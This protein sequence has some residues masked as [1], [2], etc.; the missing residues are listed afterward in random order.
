MDMHTFKELLDRRIRSTVDTLA[1]KSSEYSTD[2][3]LHNFK[4]AA[5]T[6]GSSPGEVCWNYMMKHL[7]SIQDMATGKKVFP[8]ELMREKIGD[9]I[10]YLILM[11]AILTEG[12][13]S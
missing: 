6:F 9:A 5:K 1:A 2:D 13:K 3:K 12:N 10:N 8:P 11:E 4:E 7:V